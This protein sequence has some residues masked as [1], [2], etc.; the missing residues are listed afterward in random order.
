MLDSLPRGWAR[1]RALGAVLE[2]GGPA[3][4][5]AALDLIADLSQERDRVWALTALIAGR[6]LGQEELEAALDLVETAAGRRRLTNR[7]RQAG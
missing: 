5:G 7:Y 6:S 3:T 1:R 2:A 4:V